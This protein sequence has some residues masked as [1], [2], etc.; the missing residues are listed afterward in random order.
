[1]GRA[2]PT[3]EWQRIK[4]V[5]DAQ[6]LARAARREVPQ[7]TKLQ[8]RKTPNLSGGE[9]DTENANS[10]VRKPILLGSVRIPP[11]LSI[12]WE[13]RHRRPTGGALPLQRCRNTFLGWHPS[14]RGGVAA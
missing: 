6:A 12:S 8:W 2:P 11:L 1:V 14:W 4:T 10:K 3:N 7:K 13:G 9:T 5:E